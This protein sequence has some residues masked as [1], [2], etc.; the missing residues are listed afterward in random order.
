[1]NYS[2]KHGRGRYDGS[3]H[4]RE[5]AMSD[6][7]TRLWAGVGIMAGVGGACLLDILTRLMGVG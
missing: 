1:M 3:V 2:T 7:E 5:R 4:H 6:R